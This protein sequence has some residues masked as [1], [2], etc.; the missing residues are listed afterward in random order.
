[1]NSIP[2]KLIE[3]IDKDTIIC[4]CEDVTKNEILRVVDQ[5]AKDINQIKSWTRLGMGPC[6]GRTCQYSTSKIVAEYLN[7]EIMI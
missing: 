7:S 2:K 4:R 1:M 3:N 5:G 6:Q